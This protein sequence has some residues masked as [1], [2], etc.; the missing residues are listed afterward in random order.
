MPIIIHF[1]LFIRCYPVIL[2]LSGKVAPPTGARGNK[3]EKE[4]QYRVEWQFKNDVF[5]EGIFVEAW[6]VGHEIMAVNKTF[7]VTDTVGI[8]LDWLKLAKENNC[9]LWVSE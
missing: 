3:M 8:I 4:F 6:I 5:K 7:K 2:Y 9:A 1:H